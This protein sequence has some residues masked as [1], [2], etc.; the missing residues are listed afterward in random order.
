[1]TFI[2]PGIISA[3]LL[4]YV[5]Y[6]LSQEKY[7][8]SYIPEGMIPFRLVK[9]EQKK[10]ELL[11]T[12]KEIEFEHQMGKTSLPDYNRLKQKYEIETVQVIKELEKDEAH[13]GK[14]ATIEEKIKAYRQK[15]KDRKN[16]PDNFRKNSK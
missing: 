8:F 15:I 4:T 13:S 11:A 2:I 1:M 3:V 16:E 6:P 10:N 12:L 9:L 14:R 7:R 5:F